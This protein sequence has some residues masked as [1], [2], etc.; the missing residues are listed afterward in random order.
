MDIEPDAI[1]KMWEDRGR[2]CN[3]LPVWPLNVISEAAQRMKDG[4]RMSEFWRENHLK[5]ALK[6]ANR[7]LA[8]LLE[9][10]AAVIRYPRAA[11]ARGART[12]T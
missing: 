11:P 9:K 8:Q 3:Y 2:D 12:G 7:E 1:E 5:D 4:L 6:L 10:P